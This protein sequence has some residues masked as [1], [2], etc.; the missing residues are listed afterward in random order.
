LAR[1]AAGFAAARVPAALVR[2]GETGGAGSGAA[3]AD[4]VTDR[5]FGATAA[6]GAVARRVRVSFGA[7]CFGFSAGTL[8]TAGSAAASA[9]GGAT[10]DSGPAGSTSSGDA[11]CASAL[12]PDADE[13]RRRGAIEGVAAGGGVDLER[14]FDESDLPFAMI[15]CKNEETGGT[16]SQRQGS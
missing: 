14:D 7:S 12:G 8:A 6:F 1:G 10:G 4:G 5:A 9:A 13:R 11:G 2:F 15:P 16:G 3:S